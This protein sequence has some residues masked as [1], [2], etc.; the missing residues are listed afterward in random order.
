MGVK[1]RLFANFREAA[2]KPDVQF[3]GVRS[4]SSLF[5]GL[6]ERFGSK[7]AE[8]LFGSD[9]EIRPTVNLLLNGKALKLP[10]DLGMPLND[11]DVVEIFPPVSGG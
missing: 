11:G 7:M 8:E 9:G 6:V 5:D 1:V 3:N 10:A 2:G 4:I